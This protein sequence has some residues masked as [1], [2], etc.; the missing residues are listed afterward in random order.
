MLRHFLPLAYPA[1]LATRALL[2]AIGVKA[3]QLRVLL[4]HDVAPG[5][6]ETFAET[7]RWLQKSWDFLAPSEF[8]EIMQGR[9]AL[10][11]DSLLLTFDDGFASNRI[12]TERVL[13]PLGIHAIF[14][15]VPAFIDQ[16]DSASARAFIC[17]RLRAGISPAL[18]PAHWKNMSW[19]DLSCLLELGQSIGAHTTSHERLTGDID[20]G[21]M[22][23]EI[24]GAADKLESKL[25]IRVRHFAFPFGDFASFSE[26]AMRLAMRRFDFIHSGLRGNNRPGSSPCTIRRESLKPGDRKSLVGAFLQGASDFRYRRL[27]EVLDQWALPRQ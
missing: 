1:F 7:L 10:A 6:L 5:E 23:S 22:H 3:P 21:V 25:S 14:F 24:I 2:R 26:P 18:M 11:R 4:Y 27:N 12:V 8:E 16:P 9:R 19:E 17:E 20:T 13:Q 15:V